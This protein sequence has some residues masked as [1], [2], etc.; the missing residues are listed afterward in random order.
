MSYIVILV[1]VA[2]CSYHDKAYSSMEV[3]GD[4]SLVSAEN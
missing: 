4:G 1:I 3:F 2:T